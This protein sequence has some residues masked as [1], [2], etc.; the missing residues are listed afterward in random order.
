MAAVNSAVFLHSPVFV[1][2]LL[3]PQLEAIQ[4]LL[5]IQLPLLVDVLDVVENQGAA[6]GNLL[7]PPVG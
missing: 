2:A 5:Q 7:M 6:A 3:D 4:E 1:E